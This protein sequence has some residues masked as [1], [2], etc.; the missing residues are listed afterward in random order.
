LDVLL[1][2]FGGLAV[3]GESRG[4]LFN[5]QKGVDV[6]RKEIMAAVGE[7]PHFVN[8]VESIPQF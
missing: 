7:K 3:I 4:F 6:G 5:F 1:L 8:A 2:L